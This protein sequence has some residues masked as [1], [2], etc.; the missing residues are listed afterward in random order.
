MLKDILK[1][2]PDALLCCDHTCLTLFHR[3]NSAIIGSPI[4]LFTTNYR[5]HTHC[6]TMTS[7]GKGDGGGECGGRMGGVQR[8]VCWVY[9]GKF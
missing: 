7:R 4:S 9:L 5:S 3:L 6:P 2:I 8:P 1:K